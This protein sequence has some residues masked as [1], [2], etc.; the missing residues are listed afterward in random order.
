[1]N[2]ET[3]KDDDR[4]TVGRRLR[5]AREEQGL[6]L[7]EVGLAIKVHAH[8]VEAL[9]QGDYDALP[10]PLWARGFLIS[11]ADYLGLD[12]EYLAYRLLP[13]PRLSRP[14]RYLKRYWRALIAG[15]GILGVALAMVLATIVVP[16]NPV[17]GWIGGAFEQIAPGVFLADGPQRVVL[18]GDAE[19]G[20]TGSDN[21]LLAE[22]SEGGIGLRPIPRDTSTDIPGYGEGE[23]G[24]AFAIGGPDLTRRSVAQLTDT[25]VP[26]YCVIG[27]R[28]VREIVGSIGGVR[29][30][31]P[32]A[33]S[34]KSAPGRPVMTLQPGSQTLNANEA[35]VYLQ[36]NDLPNDEQ[37][38]KRQQ[39]F[40][41]AMY[42][43]ALGPSNLL[44]NPS[45]LNTVLGYTET[46]MNGVQILQLAG[47][48]QASEEGGE[49]AVGS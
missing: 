7:D 46:N 17:T 27:T 48:I 35:L 16:Y 31:V 9:E 37:R 28:G 11:Y 24:D 44:S 20:I 47:R 12:R 2:V 22:I 30:R 42:R 29:V 14:R 8:H 45:T 41:Y 36:G 39:E 10:S 23:V 18:L 21:V 19:V 3:K 5:R 49:R 40:L 25:E 33:T 34:G 6:T 43:Q 1:M 38:A 13:R 4:R 15:L 26:Y 32:Q